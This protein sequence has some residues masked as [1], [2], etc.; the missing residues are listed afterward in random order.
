MGLLLS[1][2]LFFTVICSLIVLPAFSGKRVW[3]L[4]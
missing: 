1:I 4:A 2:G 3:L